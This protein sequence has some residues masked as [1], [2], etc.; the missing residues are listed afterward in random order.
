MDAYTLTRDLNTCEYFEEVLS[1]SLRAPKGRGN[2]IG[3]ASSS[4][5]AETPRNDMG[6][7]IANLIINKKISTELTVGEFIKE[8][9]ELLRP[10]ETDTKLLDEVVN[11]LMNANPKVVADYKG[12]KQGAIMFLVGQVMKEMKGKADANTV[13]AK[14]KDLLK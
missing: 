13:I 10:K 6:Q 14:L 8:T 11:K 4:G 12:G 5:S 2:L 9:T 1:L 7:A 3:T